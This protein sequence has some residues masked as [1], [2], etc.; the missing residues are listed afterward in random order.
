MMYPAYKLNKQSDNM[1]PCPAPFPI[2]NQSVAHLLFLDARKGFSG[3]LIY[4]LKQLVHRMFSESIV[5]L[6]LVIP[7]IWK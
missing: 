4:P 3:D 5:E 6:A 1:Q 7:W 2:L